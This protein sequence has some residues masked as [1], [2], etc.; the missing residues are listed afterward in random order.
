MAQHSNVL[1]HCFWRRALQRVGAGR[2]APP[3]NARRRLWLPSMLIMSMSYLPIYARAAD[4]YALHHRRST[5]VVMMVGGM[6]DIDVDAPPAV[7]R[8]VIAPVTSPPPSDE[9]NDLSVVIEPGRPLPDASTAPARSTASRLMALAPMVDE[10]AHAAGMDSA[11]LMAVIDVESGGNP[12]AMSPKGATGL[13]QLM[14]DT[15]A[16][17]GATN[18][19]DPR[20]N[21]SA[22]ARYLRQLMQQFGDLQ[23]A[24]AA[25][26]AGEGAVQKYGG[27]I[28]PYKETINYVPRVMGRYLH[29]RTAAG[30]TN[31]IVSGA[32]ADATQGRF[33][34]VRQNDEARD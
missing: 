24:L 22:G 34:L 20:Q 4:P 2:R 3:P 10:I 13:M 11:L 12:Q 31:G 7:V 33:L 29:Y 32:A 16:R 8:Q 27:Q 28:P 5:G 17:Q 23:L 1:M 15:G 25:Y 18:L 19:F 6:A 14:P 30:S 9:A 26:N 21:I